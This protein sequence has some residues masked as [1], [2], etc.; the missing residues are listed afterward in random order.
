MLSQYLAS[1]SV[2][3]LREACVVFSLHVLTCLRLAL[4][5]ASRCCVPRWSLCSL[6]SLRLHLGCH[7]FCVRRNTESNWLQIGEAVLGWLSFILM[8]WR[9]ENCTK[10]ERYLSY[11]VIWIDLQINLFF[12]FFLFLIGLSSHQQHQVFFETHFFF[13]A[14]R[15]F[16]RLSG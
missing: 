6:W 3:F 10:S 8:C 16:L 2:V 15:T 1:S 11:D 13:S 4:Q 5:V 12:S 9:S 7:T 14:T